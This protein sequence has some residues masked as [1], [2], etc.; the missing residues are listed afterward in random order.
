L[1][2]LIIGIYFIEVD[3]FGRSENIVCNIIQG[4]G[5]VVNI[6]TVEGGNEITAELGKDLMGKIVIYMLQVFDL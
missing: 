4:R 5:E 1:N 6:L 3:L 2:A